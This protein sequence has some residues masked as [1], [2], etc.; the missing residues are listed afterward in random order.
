MPT[1][2]A[3]KSF[4]KHDHHHCLEEAILRAEQ[5]C[6]DQG[7]RFTKLRR[8]ILKMIWSSHEPVKA[9]D[10]LDEL[11]KVHP[12][13]A[14]PTVYR[15]LD[16]LLDVGLIHKIESLNAYLGC[17][18]PD[19]GHSGQ[20]LICRKCSSVAELHDAGM[21][22]KIQSM[23]RAVNFSFDKMIIEI[24]GLCEDCRQL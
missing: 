18:D 20:F 24:T 10:L 12:G 16:F 14:P 4:H 8:Q 11:K 17:G 22:R 2:P 9:Y 15:A 23:T 3:P 6:A 19:S 7:E 21:T 5:K 13:S 1:I